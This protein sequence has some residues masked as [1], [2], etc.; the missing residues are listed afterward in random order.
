MNDSMSEGITH[1]LQTGAPLTGAAAI[2]GIAGL[3]SYFIVPM[4]V[5]VSN[6]VFGVE[7]ASI[8]KLQVVS[9]C[10]VVTTLIV[11]VA[12]HSGTPVLEQ[13]ATGWLAA[14]A[15][16]GFNQLTQK[17]QEASRPAPEPQPA[18]RTTYDPPAIRTQ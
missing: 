14:K 13:I 5:G 10:G 17:A 8:Y 15:A 12:T 3:L 9:L 16:V 4:V 7:F 2:A 6:K 11:G 1:W 18:L